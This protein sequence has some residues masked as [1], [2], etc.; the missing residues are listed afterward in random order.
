MVFSFFLIILDFQA[1]HHVL[2]AVSPNPVT[3]I[4]SIVSTVKEYKTVKEENERLRKQLAYMVL[5]RITY[6]ELIRENENLNRLLGFKQYSSF[7]LIP[8][9]II[10]RSEDY[11][12]FSL[13]I[14]KGYRNGLYR[15]SVVIGVNG[16]VGKLIKVMANY[17]IVQTYYDLNFRISA[18]DIKTNQIG[19]VSWDGR[20]KNLTFQVSADVD[21]SEGSRIIS[22]GIGG[23]YP[24]GLDIGVVGPGPYDRSTLFLKVPV[25]PSQSL[26]A[27]DNVFVISGDLV[28]S[29]SLEMSDFQGELIFEISDW[30][31]VFTVN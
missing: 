10:S 25:I 20:G 27:M 17:S 31:L 4:L 13:T 26:S 22:T 6:E 29:D 16:I 2:S 15:N 5:N 18:M 12:N 21:I 19:I 1:R 7:R 8:A 9:E 23:I 30:R 3:K 28:E 14:G 24:R 11:A